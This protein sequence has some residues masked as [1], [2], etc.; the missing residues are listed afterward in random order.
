MPFAQVRAH[1]N[2]CVVHSGLK[3]SERYYII[4]NRASN[5][6]AVPHSE[7]ADIQDIILYSVAFVFCLLS[8][9]VSLL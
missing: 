3:W 6:A 1:C 8:V 5:T 9:C 7:T 2:Y 4:Y